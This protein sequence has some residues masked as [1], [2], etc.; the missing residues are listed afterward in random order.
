MALLLYQ[1]DILEVKDFQETMLN[2]CLY[3]LGMIIIY[4]VMTYDSI[5][6]LCQC[7]FN[8]TTN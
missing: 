8:I 5:V 7:L 6:Q 4:K 2:E 3:A 1:I